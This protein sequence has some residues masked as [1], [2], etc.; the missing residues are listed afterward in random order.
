MKLMSNFISVF[1]TQIIK[2]GDNTPTKLSVIMYVYFQMFYNFGSLFYKNW[3]QSL[4]RVKPLRNYKLLKRKFSN[5]KIKDKLL[6]NVIYIGHESFLN[7]LYPD[8]IPFSMKP[9]DYGFYPVKINIKINIELIKWSRETLYGKNLEISRAGFITKNTEGLQCDFTGKNT[10]NNIQPNNWVNLIVPNGTLKDASNNLPIIDINNPLTYKVQNFLGQD[11]YKNEGFAVNPTQNIIDLSQYISTTWEN[12]LKEQ[13]DLILDLY[14]NLTD[15]QK[16]TAELFAGSFK[17]VLPPPGFFIIIAG[18]LSQKYNQSLTNDIKMYFSL[19]AGLFDA[20]V[21]AWWYKYTYNQPRPISLIRYYYKNIMINSWSPTNPNVT[22]INMNGA[23]WLPYQDYTFVTPPFPDVASG[24]TTFSI[25]A[26][27]I[28]DW[29]FKK[30]V[31]YDGFTLV[32]NSNPNELCPSANIGDKV[33]CIGEYVFSPG[34]IVIDGVSP[35]KQVI[36]RY[37]KIEDMYKAAGLSRVYGGIHTFQTND[38]SSKLGEWVVEKSIKKLESSFK[39]SVPC[40]YSKN[41]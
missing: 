23:Q 41:E 35:K 8:Y 27:K 9:L 33:S 17:N 3:I 31:L 21:S 1:F 38:V 6:K 20:S 30:P 25:V 34:T 15:E 24:H 36:L 11:Y 13:T 26:G 37:K 39:F 4:D 14:K 22:A 40:C 32:E 29:W 16:C 19:G 10:F 28:L 2:H 7:A 12:G 18:Q 5:S